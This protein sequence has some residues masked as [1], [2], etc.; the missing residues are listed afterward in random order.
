MKL[1]FGFLSKKNA[2]NLLCLPY[3]YRYFY[4]LRNV[5]CVNIKTYLLKEDGVCEV[6]IIRTLLKCLC[7]RN[8][9]WQQLNFY[10]TIHFDTFVGAE[11]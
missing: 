3:V 10:E 9:K 4:L 1:S 6:Q 2:I 11:F 5:Q 8:E 7:C